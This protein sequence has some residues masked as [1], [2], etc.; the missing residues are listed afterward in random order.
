MELR[1]RA[2]HVFSESKRVHAFRSLCMSEMTRS[3]EDAVLQQLAQ[4][5]DESHAS[6]RDDYECSSSA[7]DVL[8]AEAKVCKRGW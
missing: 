7:L 8:V 1:K 4:L 5:M 6:C 2:R 3:G